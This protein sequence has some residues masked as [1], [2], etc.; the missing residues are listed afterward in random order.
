MSGQEPTPGPEGEE[1][2]RV[3]EMTTALEAARESSGTGNGPRDPFDGSQDYTS[4]RRRVRT[5]LLFKQGT[6]T[7]KAEW[8]F[9]QLLGAAADVAMDDVDLD[10]DGTPFANPTDIIDKLD[11]VYGV[12]AGD[13][14]IDAVKQLSRLRQGSK[15]LQ[16][17]TA[18]FIPLAS[19]AKHGEE[20]KIGAFLAGLSPRLYQHVALGTYTAFSQVLNAAR[21]A[22]TV[23]PHEKKKADKERGSK[24]KNWREKRPEKKERT[25]KKSSREK[26][27]S[28]GRAADSSTECYECGKKGHFARDCKGK[29]KA[30]KESRITEVDTDDE[31]SSSLAGYE[32]GKD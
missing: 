16:E 8:L 20:A 1:D 17:Y 30:R 3:R 12:A 27:A 14:K 28:K 9:N 25:E 29:G 4:W 26:G 2:R 7:K 32:S 10:A 18:E 31:D 23:L 13:H 15:K 21:K 19:V 24:S 6:A 5:K 11:A 22:D